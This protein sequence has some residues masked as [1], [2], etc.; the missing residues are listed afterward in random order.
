MRDLQIIDKPPGA[1]GEVTYDPLAQDPRIQFT[2]AS[3]G[4]K[5]SKN[6][7][8]EWFGFWGEY[9]PSMRLLA[10]ICLTWYFVKY[11]VGSSDRRLGEAVDVPWLF[12]LN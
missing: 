3:L 1:H 10:Y 7:R 2:H 8:T 11:L 12:R 9:V 4:L 6:H 5:W